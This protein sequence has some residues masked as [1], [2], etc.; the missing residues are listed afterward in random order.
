MCTLTQYRTVF[1]NISI[2]IGSN[3]YTLPPTSYVGRYGNHCYLLFTTSGSVKNSSGTYWILGANFLHNYY[4]VFDMENDRIGLVGGVTVYPEV[5]D[6]E[7][8]SAYIGILL[9]IFAVLMIIYARCCR[10]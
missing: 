8:F 7:D 9:M 6:F 10:K 3:S 1:E 4:A 5:T 2:T